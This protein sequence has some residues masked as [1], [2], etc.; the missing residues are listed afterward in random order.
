MG[1]PLVENRALLPGEIDELSSEAARLR[2]RGCLMGGCAPLVFFIPIIVLASVD[3]LLKGAPAIQGW[4]VLGMVFAFAAMAAY[5]L[6]ANDYFK[7]SKALRR[8]LQTATIKRFVGPRSM[9]QDTSQQNYT[10][11]Q[12]PGQAA[13]VSDRP[14][15]EFVEIEV[16]PL[17]H[18][19][20]L[21]DGQ[22]VGGWEE[23]HWSEVATA[24]HFASMAAAWVEPL[25]APSRSSQEPQILDSNQHGQRDLSAAEISELQRRARKAWLRPFWPAFFLTLWLCIPLSIR[26]FTNE[27]IR[28][29]PMAFLLLFFTGLAY[30]AL[31]QGLVAAWS[32]RKDIEIGIAVIL[33]VPVSI[34]Y[35][36]VSNGTPPAPTP[37]DG[38]PQEANTVIEILPYSRLDW[39][40][41]GKPAAWRKIPTD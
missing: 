40:E 37:E 20:W 9:Y 31:L 4:F 8:D 24:P 19:L 1:L 29:G 39:T 30:Y 28:N 25:R 22:V 7:Q 35:G 16:L 21:R 33:R 15:P 34:L 32:L 6:K 36:F 13:P 3:H 11:A 12:Q 10:Q 41:N 38:T 14:E 2:S 27:P 5:F 17:S 26:L 18:R 23:A